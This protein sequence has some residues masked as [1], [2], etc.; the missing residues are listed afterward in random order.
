MARILISFI[1]GLYSFAVF[2]KDFSIQLPEGWREVKD[3]YGIPVTLLGPSVAPKPRAV[4]QVIPTKLPPAKMNHTEAVAFGIKYAEGR[5]NWMKDQEG[6]IFEILP[7]KFEGN[8]FVAGVSYRL[9][10]KNF[11]E[12]TYYVNCPKEIFHLKI[13]LNFENRDQLS[14]SES[15]VR[16]FS[17]AD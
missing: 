15:I 6:E 10:Q 3:L 5:K 7:G 12:R 14:Q 1:L 17:C 9:N 8:R 11:I 16:S 13:I 2:A 4:I